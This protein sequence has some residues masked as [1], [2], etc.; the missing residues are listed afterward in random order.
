MIRGEELTEE[1]N[2]ILEQVKLKSKQI[3]VSE[4][5]SDKA[6]KIGA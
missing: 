5:K 2:E 6:L 3:H 4:T 1:A